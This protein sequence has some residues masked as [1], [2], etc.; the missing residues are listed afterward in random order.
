MPESIL[1]PVPAEDRAD[2]QASV[3]PEPELAPLTHDIEAPEADAIDQATEL[4]PEPD[5]R[6]A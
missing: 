5:F 2:Q 1:D 6:D 3:E 4:P